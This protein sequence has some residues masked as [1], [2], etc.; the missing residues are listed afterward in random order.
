MRDRVAH[1]WRKKPA[2]LHYR[3]CHKSEELFLKQYKGKRVTF[4]DHEEVMY[5]CGTKTHEGVFAEA[6][7]H[8]GFGMGVL[9]VALDGSKFIAETEYEQGFP[10]E[11]YGGQS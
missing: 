1:E 11:V 4:Q 7:E 8:L 3:I 10:S 5:L 2:R 6:A 9:I